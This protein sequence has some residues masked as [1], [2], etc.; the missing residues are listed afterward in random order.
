M[1]MGGWGL[2][3]RWEGSQGRWGVTS[4]ESPQSCSCLP[5][6]NL[7]T[8]AGPGDPR[9]RTGAARV[10]GRLQAVAVGRVRK[11]LWSQPCPLVGS[12][13]LR[14]QPPGTRR[15]AVSRQHLPGTEGGLLRAAEVT[16]GVR[17]GCSPC[18]SNHCPS[19]VQGPGPSTAAR[20]PHP[21]TCWAPHSSATAPR[22][23]G[24]RA[25]TLSAPSPTAVPATP[26]A[27]TL[28]ASGGRPRPGPDV[29][30]PTGCP[31]GRVLTG[32][33]STEDVHG[34]GGARETTQIFGR[35]PGSHHIPLDRCGP[36]RV[37]SGRAQFW[38]QKR[39]VSGAEDHPVLTA[40][41]P[42]HR[43]QGRSK[44]HLPAPTQGPPRISRLGE[45]APPTVPGLYALLISPP[46]LSPGMAFRS[47]NGAGVCPA[48]C[49]RWQS[50]EKAQQAQQSMR[51]GLWA[52]CRGTQGPAAL[53]G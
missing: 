35:H 23:R 10:P 33:G 29:P 27:T 6:Q 9:Q 22:H 37:R 5:Q 46:K 4:Q 28:A 38:G 18:C 31:R 11:G 13:R 7:P 24:S 44:G 53:P 51:A 47:R 17:W 52:T 14:G 36:R 49:T 50:Q 40:H 43:G 39:W 12:W 3:G 8:P 32:P 21:A 25:P 42:G 2:R 15:A 16:P 20:H 19:Q 45:G 1:R 30:L 34:A 41:W 48:T 26:M